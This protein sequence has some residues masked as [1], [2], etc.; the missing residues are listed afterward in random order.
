MK[1][2]VIIRSI[3]ERTARLSYES[4]KAF[5]PPGTTFHKLENLFPAYQLYQNMFQ[6]A[7]QE[8]FDW[9]F[10]VDA[11]VILLPSWPDVIQRAIDTFS[12]DPNVFRI[13]MLTND[14]LSQRWLS[15]GVHLYRGTHSAHLLSTITQLIEK[16]DT[17][18]PQL[19][20]LIK[21][22]GMTTQALIREGG[23]LEHINER[24]G[25][26]GVEQ[27]YAEIFRRF[28]VRRIREPE[29]H[30][31]STFLTKWLDPRNAQ[32]LLQQDDMDGYV[33]NMAWNTTDTQFNIMS[34][35]GRIKDD[36]NIWLQNAGILEKGPLTMSLDDFYRQYPIM[37]QKRPR[38]W[39]R[40]CTFFK[41]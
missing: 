15:A 21:P 36:I 4:A 18:N 9:Y 3:G 31:Q 39:T 8:N 38:L 7:V 23:K 11:D 17:T 27:F 22:E 28:L 35:D 19:N 14:V 16:H 20:I 10:A 1:F 32:K 40:V 6:L 2:G 34:N 41:S 33:A 25:Y 13:T 12:S 5:A 26:H 37:L 30:R 29:Y 24:V